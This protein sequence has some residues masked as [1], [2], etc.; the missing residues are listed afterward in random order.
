MKTSSLGFQEDTIIA[1]VDI[2]RIQLERSVSLFIQ[3]DY[4]SAVTLSGAA[5]AILA[6]LLSEERTASAVEDS[7]QA[8]RRIEEN[9][10]INA[11]NGLKDHEIYKKWNDARNNFKHHRRGDAA[12]ITVN[13]FDESYWMIKRALEN[14]RKLDVKI[15]NHDDFENWV[16]VNI[17]M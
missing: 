2:A 12:I 1:K 16:I 5:E 9:L 13:L 3:G 6:G 17:C 4:I 7:T 8:I 10:G 11:M 15:T 14:S